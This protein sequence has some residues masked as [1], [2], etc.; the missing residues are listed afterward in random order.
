[1]SAQDAGGDSATRPPVEPPRG[2]GSVLVNGTTNERLGSAT[3]GQNLS[4]RLGNPNLEDL[5]QLGDRPDPVGAD[6]GSLPP[7][8]LIDP[9]YEI[10]EQGARVM[11]TVEQGQYG[12]QREPPTPVTPSSATVRVQEFFTTQSTS[13]Q[14][15]QGIR[16]MARFSEFLR[17]TATR[18][19]HGM[20][21]M[22]DG[23]G[24]PSMPAGRQVQVG[25]ALQ[26]N[27]SPPEELPPAPVQVPGIPGSWR[28]S[29]APN[30][31]LFGPLQVAQMRQ[32]QVD[33]PLLYGPQGPSQGSE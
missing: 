19:V 11:T 2:S 29:P 9:P 26:L 33:F 15:P 7:P 1:M 24:I 32:A 12:P 27:V 4:G 13:P 3:P 6:R 17:A 31:P 14:E 20:D 16:W 22:L 10:P 18:G 5:V 8:H 21:R 28:T 25:N 30:P 23:L